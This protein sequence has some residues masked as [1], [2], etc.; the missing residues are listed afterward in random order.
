MGRLPAFAIELTKRIPHGA[1]LG[2]GSCDAA[3]VIAGARALLWASSQHDP[4]SSSLQPRAVGADVPFFLHGGAALMTGRGDVLVRTTPPRST[5]R[6]SSCV[7]PACRSRPPPRTARSTRRRCPPGD[8]IALIAGLE[9]RR[10]L[11]RSRAALSNNFE[12]VSA[13]LVPRGGRRRSHGVRSARA[14]FGRDGRGQR[15]A[16]FGSAT[17]R[18]ETRPTVAAQAGRRGLVVGCDADRLARARP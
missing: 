18:R 13:A 12:A 10:L 14:C 4:M 2:G 8:P 3:A 16:V 6:S 11:R 15:S 7:K 9:A 17:L 5:R 1:G